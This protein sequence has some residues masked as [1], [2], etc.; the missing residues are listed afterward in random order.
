MELSLLCTSAI[1]WHLLGICD[2]IQG[3]VDH[4]MVEDEPTIAAHIYRE[5]LKIADSR[6]RTR[7][8]LSR[9]IR[10]ALF[11]FRLN[12][13]HGKVFMQWIMQDP[14]KFAEAVFGVLEV[15]GQRNGTSQANSHIFH[16]HM[17][18]VAVSPSEA[19]LPPFPRITIAECIARLP[20]SQR[21]LRWHDVAILK[22][23]ADQNKIFSPDDLPVASCSFFATGVYMTGFGELVEK[24]DHI[25]GFLDL[26]LLRNLDDGTKKQITKLQVERGWHITRFEDD[27][28]GSQSDAVLSVQQLVLRSAT[29]RMPS[30]EKNS[31]CEWTRLF[32]RRL[33][34]CV[35]ENG[36]GES[37]QQERQQ[38]PSSEIAHVSFSAGV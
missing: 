16:L 22:K 17:L 5:V 28:S 31:R 2:G 7:S 30:S 33:R 8:W 32:V 29:E 11:N 9:D 18:A 4:S 25:N 36:T 13:A 14:N 19:S 34:S 26:S 3:T 35:C 23:C 10:R 21:E 38:E 6:K 20:A 24:P 15:F 37:G 27:E 1:N 12:M